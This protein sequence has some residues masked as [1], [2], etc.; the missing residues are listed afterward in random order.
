[1]ANSFSLASCYV[2]HQP[3]ICWECAKACGGCTWSAKFEPVAGWSAVKTAV[4]HVSHGKRE[5]AET[6]RI[7][8]CPEFE[9]EVCGDTD[10]D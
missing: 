6:Y 9:Q 4:C 2:K 5:W 7:S 1:M 3:Q 10:Y 8:S